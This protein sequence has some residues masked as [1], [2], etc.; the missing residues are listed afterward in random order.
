MTLPQLLPALEQTQERWLLCEPTAL[1]AAGGEEYV[2][3]LTHN[4]L[5][6]VISSRVS[7]ALGFFSSCS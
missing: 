2:L 5:K 3:Q 6:T 1:L 7:M 4:S